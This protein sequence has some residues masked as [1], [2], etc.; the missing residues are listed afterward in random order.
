MNRT[1]SRTSAIAVG[2]MVDLALQSRAGPVRLA[3]IGQRQQISKSYLDPLFGRLRRHALVRATRGPGGGYSLGR[4]A[5]QISVADIV[6]AVDKSCGVAARGRMAPR[7]RDGAGHGLT[8]ALWNE[9]D[10]KLIAWLATMPLQALVDEQLARDAQSK[11]TGLERAFSPRPVARPIEPTI[12][13]SVFALGTAP[14]SRASS[15]KTAANASAA[16][17]PRHGL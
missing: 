7:Q 12:P 14:L 9:L 16:R 8:H 5:A 4:D 13:N 17:E 1:L 10:A 3:V 15:H 6:V 11:A 2:A